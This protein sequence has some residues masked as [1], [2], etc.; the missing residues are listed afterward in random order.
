MDYTFN[1]RTVIVD[2]PSDETTLK[3]VYLCFHG[4]SGNAG[5]FKAQLALEPQDAYVIYLTASGS[6]TTWRIN[7]NADAEVGYINWVLKELKVIY[8]N[9]DVNNIINI[10]HSNGG[11]MACTY[12]HYEPVRVKKV[13]L[14]NSYVVQTT[15][16]FNG[17]VRHIHAIDDAII[18]YEGGANHPSVA[19]TGAVF[20]AAGANYLLMDINGDHT[21]N[22]IKTRLPLDWGLTLSNVIGS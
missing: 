9:M 16:N 20:K 13:I 8:P 17:Q 19:E 15:T 10:G 4:W 3:P 6:P 2:L 22:S 1:G 5:T 11:T 14:L 12:A 18:S 7:I 21:M